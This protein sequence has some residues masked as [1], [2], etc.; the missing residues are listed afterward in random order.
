MAIT[1]QKQGMTLI[2]AGVTI[3]ILALI[4]FVAGRGQSPNK[5][6]PTIATETTMTT[7]TLQTT[8]G[9][10]VLEL[11]NDLAPK[12]VDNFVTL[13]EQDFYDG[14]RFHRVMD[15]FMI[16][17]GDPTTKDLALESAW[18][19]GGPG[20]QLDDEIYAENSNVAGTI[21][22][23]NSGR[24]NTNGSQ[25]FINVADN[26]FLDPKHTVFGRVLEGMDVVEVI[27][28]KPTTG[29]PLDRPLEDIVI[30]DVVVES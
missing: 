19:T 9:D 11:F 14:V 8:E 21:S 18:G 27:S 22:M 20:Y 10:I 28:K 6:L 25:F 4:I 3:I 5:E 30:N 17:S 12:T 15:G 2:Y 24:P 29:A 16:Q 7:V 26:N 13:A 23:A 1:P